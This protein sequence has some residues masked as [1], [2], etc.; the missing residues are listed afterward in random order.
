MPILQ[1]LADGSFRVTVPKAIA[2]GKN[3]KG[4]DEL[5]FCVVDQEINRPLPG[6]IYIR[7]NR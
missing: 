4:G 3:W 6:D 7:R 1:E 5:G 2:K